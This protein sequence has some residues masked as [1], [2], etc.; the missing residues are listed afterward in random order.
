MG[1]DES[2]KGGS[3]SISMRRA[4][5]RLTRSLHRFTSTDRLR[6]LLNLSIDVLSDALC[7]FIEEL[8]SVTS[9]EETRSPE[10]F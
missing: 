7:H 10:A 5:R 8:D 4:D 1:V 9:R 2:V 3:I 6:K